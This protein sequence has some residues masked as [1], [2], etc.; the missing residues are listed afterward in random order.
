MLY[1]LFGLLVLPFPTTRTSCDLGVGEEKFMLK[2]FEK[3]KQKK[4]NFSKNL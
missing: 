2:I 1:D 3:E 4:E